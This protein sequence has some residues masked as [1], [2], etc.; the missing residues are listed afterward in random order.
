MWQS[1]WG[2]RN[3]IVIII[4]L[5]MCQ[6]LLWCDFG[7]ERL[8]ANLCTTGEKADQIARGLHHSPRHH[9]HS[10]PNC[11]SFLRHRHHHCQNHHHHHLHISFNWPSL[12]LSALSAAAVELMFSIFGCLDNQNDR[13]IVKSTLKFHY[14]FNCSSFPGHERLPFAN[15]VQWKAWQNPC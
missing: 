13:A 6:C 5:I 4:L 3:L 12:A 2:W 7:G 11:H 14:C 15:I 8:V 1:L 9:H 10:L